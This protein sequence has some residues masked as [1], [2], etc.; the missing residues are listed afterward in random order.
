[1]VHHSS[2]VELASLHQNRKKTRRVLH[3]LQTLKNEKIR[4]TAKVL[5]R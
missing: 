3:D 2:Y 4:D 1:M 5:E